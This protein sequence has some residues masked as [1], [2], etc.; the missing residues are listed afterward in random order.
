[1]DILISIIV[2]IYNV[3]KYLDK[4]IDSIINQ[5]YTNLEIIL[6]DDGSP[7]NCPRICDQWAL[8]D[9]RIIVIH[10]PNGG[11][12]DA[13]N[14]GIDIAK[15]DYFFFLDSDDWIRKDA[16][17]ILYSLLNEKDADISCCGVELKDEEGM[18]I[19]KWSDENCPTLMDSDQSME[20]Y[21][22][23]ISIGSIAWNKLYK[24]ELFKEI[25]YPFG[26]LHE[27]EFTTWK[28]IFKSQ[29]IAYTPDCLYYYIQRKGSI[30]NSK[31]SIKHLD[32][33]SAME[34][35]WEY[36]EQEKKLQLLKMIV[37]RYFRKSIELYNRYVYDS[38]G[39][40]N[41]GTSKIIELISTRRSCIFKDNTLAFVE[42]IKLVAI[43]NFSDLYNKI[44][45]SR[46]EKK[47][48]S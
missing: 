44:I 39:K 13:R 34:E 29:K 6:V 21:L 40:Q 11:L 1:M 31:I 28:L 46:Y 23:K 3:E 20:Q 35:L 30:I 10:K 5:T 45:W 32:E 37:S 33:L 14:A 7:D 41:E 17:Q 9:Q 25:R 42:R 27:D 24:A 19:S 4:C 38:H 47:C 43:I 8:K 2:P 22:S 18:S 12:S 26:K 16:I 36:L 48:R 15:G